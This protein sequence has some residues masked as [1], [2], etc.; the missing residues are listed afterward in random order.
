[1]VE[2]IAITVPAAAVRRIPSGPSTTSRTCASSS[3]VTD[4]SRAVRATSAAVA[5]AVAPSAT[6]GSVASARTSHTTSPPGQASR[7]PAIGAPMFPRPMKPTGPG[8]SSGEPGPIRASAGPVGVSS[9]GLAAGFAVM[10][11]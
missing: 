9:A 5:T 1:M 4:T 7:R 8:E 10:T 11:G 2:W 3:T 6:N